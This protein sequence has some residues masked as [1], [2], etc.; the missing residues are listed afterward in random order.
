M[1]RE[2]D[3]LR[4]VAERFG[5]VSVLMQ[6]F[7]NELTDEL[8]SANSVTLLDIAR[9]VKSADLGLLVYRADKTTPDIGI[10]NSSTSDQAVEWKS[11]RPQSSEEAENY[12]FQPQIVVGGEPCD[13]NVWLRAA[14]GN[15]ISGYLFP[16]LR[17]DK[18]VKTTRAEK[19][20]I[21]STPEGRAVAE[22][23]G[24]ILKFV[25]VVR[26]WIYD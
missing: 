16:L 13:N 2:K 15:E 8:A 10:I 25:R 18:I 9:S 17:G 20:A 3:H 14:S 23:H 4:A 6:L 11:L 5:N 7:D 19:E 26:C 1:I 22:M 21:V 12:A 24:S